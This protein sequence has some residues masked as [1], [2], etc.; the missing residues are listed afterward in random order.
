MERGKGSEY[1]WKTAFQKSTL[2]DFSGLSFKCD[3]NLF[4][5]ISLQ[6]LPLSHYHHS[7]QFST[8]NHEVFG[9]SLQSHYHILYPACVLQ[10]WT[11]IRKYHY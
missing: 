6:N 5:L 1:I 4:F 3:L 10:K 7:Y 9:Q 11:A 2:V 8:S